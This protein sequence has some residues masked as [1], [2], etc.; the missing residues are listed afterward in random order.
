MA[1]QHGRHSPDLREIL[2][3]R[4]YRPPCN[5]A[6]SKGLAPV[7][8]HVLSFH[9]TRIGWVKMQPAE[10]IQALSDEIDNWISGQAEFSLRR[11]IQEC[12]KL[13]KVTSHS[14]ADVIYSI[15]GTAHMRL[16]DTNEALRCYENA[17]RLKPSDG[18][19]KRNV[20]TVL[21]VLGRVSDAV[22]MFAE[23]LD[24]PDN[25]RFLTYANMAEALA[26][27]GLHEDAYDAFQEALATAN[28]NSPHDA[29]LLAAQAADIGA[30][31][32]AVDLFA[33]HIRLRQGAW[34]NRSS[35][36]V[37]REAPE[38]L[39]AGLVHARAL[40]DVIARAEAFANDLSAYMENEPADRR[41]R[42][43]ATG[44]TNL[45]EFE[46]TRELRMMANT[47]VLSGETNAQ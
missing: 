29:L 14:D 17:V 47:A 27:L 3:A 23:A 19:H 30:D 26:L 34:S 16:G 32:E 1:D 39:K 18:R 7:P 40:S 38:H 22:Q 46:A 31:R 24:L 2:T 36:E 8:P 12:L 20:G 25:R 4:E 15:M 42:W 5:V 33:R 35:V 9:W 28:L 13:L 37:I 10:K 45:E 11:I 43:T 41:Q 6:V 21:I 44:Y